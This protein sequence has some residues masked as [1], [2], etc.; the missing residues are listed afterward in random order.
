[1]EFELV[2]A[3]TRPD[4]KEQAAGAFRER[5]PEFIFHDP[6]APKYMDRVGEYFG[7]YDIWF[8]QDG[9]VAAGGWGV[10]IVWDGTPEDPPEGYDATLVA[11]VEGHEATRVPDTFSV[12]GAV[13][14]SAYDKQG[15]SRRV[16][17]ALV[18]RAV[19]G[20]LPRVVAPVRPIW[21]DKY[22]QVSMA[23]YATWTRDDGLS[24]D[25][26]IRTHQRMGATIVRAAP[27][28]LVI[29]GT[30]AEWEAWAQMPFPVSGAYAV[31]G[32]LN[33]VEVDREGDRAVYREE[34]LWMRHR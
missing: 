26:W 19:A 7:S 12:M 24:I 28:S 5:W 27:N 32:A 20:G 10:P 33:L 31:P 13:V 15:L 16:L 9:H 34:N 17:E 29:P 23:D 14:A 4:L 22:P 25:P 3:T 6:V 21:K 18:E 2:A 11:S 30:V 1:M 8:L